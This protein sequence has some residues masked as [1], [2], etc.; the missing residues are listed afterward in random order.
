MFIYVEVNV[1]R[2]QRTGTDS[3]KGNQ[4]ALSEDGEAIRIQGNKSGRGSIRGRTV[5]METGVTGIQGEEW[6]GNQLK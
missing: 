3:Q 5:Q 2:S 6:R 1:N 4:E